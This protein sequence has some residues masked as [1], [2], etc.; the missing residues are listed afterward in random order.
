MQKEKTSRKTLTQNV[1]IRTDARTDGRTDGKMKIIYPSTYFV[2]RGYNNVDLD[3]H[4]F[5]LTV[6]RGKWDYIL[7]VQVRNMS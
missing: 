4:L 5:S 1:N 7:H 6:I 3:I 2:C